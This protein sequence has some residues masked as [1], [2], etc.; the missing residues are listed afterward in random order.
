MAPPERTAQYCSDLVAGLADSG[1]RVVFTSPGSRNTAM[2]LAFVNEKRIEV[3]PIRDERSGGFAA[4]GFGK[5]TGQPV[6]TL[7]TSGTAAAHYLPAMVEANHANVP[8]IVITADRPNRVRGTDAP[9][10]TDQL[11]LYGSHAVS[12]HN[13][14]VENGDGRSDAHIVTHEALSSP[15]GGVHMN[16]PLDDPR[17]PAVLPTSVPESPPSVSPT[18]H[19]RQ[20]EIFEL[21]EDKRVLIIASGRQRSDFADVVNDVA[22]ALNAPVFAD[23]QCWV[24]GPNT[25]LHPDLIARTGDVLVRNE[26]DIVLRLGP[27]PTSQALRTWLARAGVEQILVN[28]SRLGDSLGGAT[29]A[30]DADPTSFLVG[31]SRVAYSNRSYLDTWL[32]LG[33]SAAV[34]VASG[35]SRLSFP[36][37]PEIARTVVRLAEAGSIIYLASSMPIRDVDSFATPRSDIV[38]L[39][40]RGVNGID[41]LISSAIGAA[42]SGRRTTLLVGDLAALHDAA[43]LA[44]LVS[45]RIPL[46]IVVI[47]NNGGGIFSFL[48]QS[49]SDII[50]DQT[51]EN[52]WGTPHGL[53]LVNIAAA[54]GL[55][56]CVVGTFDELLDAVAP[57]VVGPELI[58]VYTNRTDNVRHHRAILDS[59]AT[60][61]SSG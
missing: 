2:T 32:D 37:E 52:H 22:F 47:N 6:G 58:E 18:L 60:V 28:N 13:L 48:A 8:L 36:N 43:A 61:L 15:A 56:T 53:R 3:V 27:I 42:L 33:S 51:F 41:G 4:L 31:A 11:E 44:E 10:A 7:C 49:Y 1:M 16:I 46:R 29:T 21:L 54:V 39:A 45:L 20:S 24:D 5:A 30:V 35:L 38:V 59:V 34:G 57:P 25:V 40:N 50:D 26:P 23:A 17:P 14:D 19:P 9:Q 55:D 12:F